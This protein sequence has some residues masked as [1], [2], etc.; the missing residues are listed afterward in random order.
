MVAP[1]HGR[2]ATAAQS[3]R[4]CAK[5]GQRAPTDQGKT[6]TDEWLIWQL[7]D[8]AFPAGGF[9]HSAGLEAAFQSELVRDPARLAE[10]IEAQLAGAAHGAAPFMLAAH[11][12]HSAEWAQVD[13]A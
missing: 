12:C 7:V 9:A 3:P 4:R 6:M 10:F 1:V 11:R 13:R 8:S 2:R 5:R